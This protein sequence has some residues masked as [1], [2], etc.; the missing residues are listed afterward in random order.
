LQ[1]GLAGIGSWL[2]VLV[3][4][5]LNAKH[6]VGRLVV[7]CLAFFK[8]KICPLSIGVSS[9]DWRFKIIGVFYFF[10]RLGFHLS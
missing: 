4:I 6:F 1:L 9:I 10:R 5:A 8:D 7:E 2:A 3:K